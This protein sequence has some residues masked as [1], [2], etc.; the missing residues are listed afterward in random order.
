LF[1]SDDQ[2]NL[3]GGTIS[4]VS[5]DKA[6]K[7]YLSRGASANKI[8]MGK[9]TY[10]QFVLYKLTSF[11]GIP[12][13]GRGFEQ[14]AGIRQP[15]NGVSELLLFALHLETKLSNLRLAQEH[16]DQGKSRLELQCVMQCLTFNL[17]VYD[18]KVL[19]FAGATVIEE[20]NNVA[21]YS[22]DSSNQELI[23]YDTPNIVE[24]KAQYMNANG[25][26]VSNLA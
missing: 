22:Y 23:S 18:Y 2:A 7:D 17:S 4:N 15:Y 20:S 26:A 13:Y 11:E 14:T 21:S 5:T 12:L 6:F 3:Y 8:N 25:M 19:P 9:L 16:G 1:Q 24:T 10:I